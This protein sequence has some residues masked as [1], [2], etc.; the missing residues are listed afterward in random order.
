MDNLA[1]RNNSY[2]PALLA[3]TYEQTVAD[4]LRGKIIIVKG[5]YKHASN[6]KNQKCYGG[7][8]YDIL[9]DTLTSTQLTLKI[10]KKLRAV[11]RDGIY[12]LLREMLRIDSRQETRLIWELSLSPIRFY[13]RRFPRLILQNSSVSLS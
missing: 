11:V 9:T 13:Q 7:F 3:R 4:D 5:I 10:H 2:T 6:S 1:Q 8:Y 12:I